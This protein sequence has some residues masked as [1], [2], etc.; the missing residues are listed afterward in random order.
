MSPLRPWARKAS[1]ERCSG[2]TASVGLALAD[3]REALVVEGDRVVGLGLRRRRRCVGLAW[4]G[5][6]ASA[7]LLR[8]GRRL[9]LRGLGLRLG[10]GLACCAA[11]ARA[12]GGGA[13]AAAVLAAGPGG[14][15]DRRARPRARARRGRPA[16]AS[17][18]VRAPAGATRTGRVGGR[19]G[20]GRDGARSTAVGGPA[21]AALAVERVLEG[22]QEV[23]GGRRALRGV[24]GHARRAARASTARGQVGAGVRWPTARCPRRGRAPGPPGGRR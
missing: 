1:T 16:R 12:L 2:G 5:P 20:A 10:L 18:A 19:G 6:A 13:G 23:R 14:D 7:G 24:L 15:G 22:V 21:G 11:R 8:L 4:S 3:E 9:R 17:G